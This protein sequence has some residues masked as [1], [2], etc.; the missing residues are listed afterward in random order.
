M[1]SYIYFQLILCRSM[2]EKKS[3][4]Y[5]DLYILDNYEYKIL[6]DQNMWKKLFSINKI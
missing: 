2:V 1:N 3:S 5:V 6:S 4:T